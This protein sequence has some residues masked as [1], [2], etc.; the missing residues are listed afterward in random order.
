MAVRARRRVVLHGRRRRGALDPRQVQGRDHQRRGEL[1]SAASSWSPCCWRGPTRSGPRARDALRVRGPQEGRI[2]AIVMRLNVS[3]A[4]SSSRP[5]REGCRRQR[6]P[7]HASGE[8][9]HAHTRPRMLRHRLDYTLALRL[10]Y[11]H[12]YFS[13]SFLWPLRMELLSMQA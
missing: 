1:T 5:A 13:D 4:S 6:P 9:R 2:D 12:G 8:H 10:A 3:A 7:V 11:I